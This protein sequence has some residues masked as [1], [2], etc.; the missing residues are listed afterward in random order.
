MKKTLTIVFA[1]ALVLGFAGCSLF[2]GGDKSPY[3]PLTEG[4]KWEYVDTMTFATDYPASIPMNDTTWS[5]YSSRIVE[6]LSKTKLTNSDAFDV[7]EVQTSTTTG[8]TTTVDT[9]YVRVDGDSIY[10]YDKIDGA[11]VSVDPANPKK[12]D[13]WTEGSD[14]LKVVADNETANGYN[15]C[16]KISTIPTDSTKNTFASYEFSTYMAKN[17]GLVMMSMNTVNKTP[18]GNDTIVS[19]VTM[20]DLLTSFTGK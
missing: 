2:G 11:T 3:Y 1:L 10:S 20:K 15:G 18:S 6:V 4:N 14:T 12:D 16:L 8:A 13:T 5:I 7:W 17:V 19:T 9:N